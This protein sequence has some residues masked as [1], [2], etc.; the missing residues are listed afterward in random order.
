MTTETSEPSK[1][2]RVGTTITIANQKG[3]VAKTTTS[4]NLAAALADAGH[5]TLLVDVD[6]QA[7]ASVSLLG[8]TPTPGADSMFEALTGEARFTDIIRPS[9]V[10]RLSVAPARISL[11][12]LERQLLGDLDAHY[13]LRDRIQH[14]RDGFDFVVIDTPPTLGL[15]TVNAL[16]ASDYLLL[17]LPPSYYALE[18]AD[19]LLDT[20]EQ[21]R[22]RPNPDLSLLGVA[23][24]LVD[25]RTRISRDAIRRI[26]RHFGRAVFRSLIHRNVRLEESPAY[27][28]SIFTF[29]PSSRGAEDYRKLSEEVLARVQANRSA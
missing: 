16:V 9:P 6:P 25:Q 13:R 17:P 1:P 21:I 2:D 18:G 4:V 22:R 29:A 12:K 24:T 19:D 27:K 10:A 11:A 5:R 15:I 7:N 14:V 28:E 3:G 26:R 20:L 23:I 8:S